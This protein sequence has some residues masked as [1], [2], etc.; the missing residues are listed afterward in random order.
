M[1][2]ADL[3]KKR[4]NGTSKIFFKKVQMRAQKACDECNKRKTKCTGGSIT[5]PCDK[6]TEFNRN[7]TFS[8]PAKKRGPST[9][10]VNS[11]V[12]T[13]ETLK[14][15]LD[16]KISLPVEVPMHS[17]VSV[18]T[19]PSA[20]GS[21]DSGMVDNEWSNSLQV[22][23]TAILQPSVQW[24]H[25]TFRLAT[26][27]GPN[28]PVPWYE[29]YYE[30]VHPQ[31]SFLYENWFLT[32]FNSLPLILLHA[33]YAA[34]TFYS[35]SPQEEG[36]FH[37]S[38][39]KAV[40]DDAIENPDP[41]KAAAVML[42]AV[43]SVNSKRLKSAIV[44]LCLAIRFCQILGID[45]DKYLIWKNTAGPLAG[46]EQESPKLFCRCLWSCLYAHDFYAIFLIGVPGSVT[47]DI[48]T[49][50]LLEYRTGDFSQPGNTP[51]RFDAC[52]I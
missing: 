6:C 39:C 22:L 8:L 1:S 18:D 46:L 5:A 28:G 43:Y 38:A 13:I 24:T 31:W 32:H 36:D 45:K 17:A 21:F 40:M 34:C 7:C 4:L 35:L 33:M 9:G 51:Q 47:L 41:F 15:K 2:H 25:D 50:Y 10:Y 52:V 27:L 29:I 19:P 12:D 23:P 3:N 20:S 42:L 48:D 11:L 49:S 37:F 44:Y 26:L 14:A 30:S 16:D